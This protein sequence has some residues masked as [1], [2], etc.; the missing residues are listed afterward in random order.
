[1]E[2]VIKFVWQFLLITSCLSLVIRIFVK[3]KDNQQLVS[4]HGIHSA[5]LAIAI[6]YLVG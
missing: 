1:V 3:N 4:L 2:E 6:K 5:V